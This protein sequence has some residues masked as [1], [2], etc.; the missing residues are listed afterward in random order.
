MIA[1]HVEIGAIEGIE[2]L[3]SLSRVRP[4]EQSNTNIFLFRVAQ[5]H[6]RIDVCI[7]LRDIR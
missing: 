4:T 5:Q 1:T 3:I 7:D 6:W 2:G